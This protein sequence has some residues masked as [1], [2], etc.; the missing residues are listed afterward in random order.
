[1]IDGGVTVGLGTDGALTN[2]SLDMLRTMYF[3]ALINKVNYGS[4][5]AM[6]AEMVLEMSTIMAARALCIDNKVGSIE[7]GKKADL[8]L[9]DL[10]TL[11]MTP[12]FL[13]IKNLVYSTSSSCVDTVIINGERIMEKRNLLTIDEEK[14]ISEAENQAWRLLELSG[15]LEKDP[16]FL[17]RGELRYI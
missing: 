2:D 11:G 5:R 17:K 10:K 7:P 15:H 9:V 8:V 1:M 4:T 13:P 3:A 6:R 16:D 14:A 12:A